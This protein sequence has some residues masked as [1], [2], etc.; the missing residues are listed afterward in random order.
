MKKRWEWGWVIWGDG[1]W[2]FIYGRLAPEEFWEQSHW[3]GPDKEF[4]PPCRV[5]TLVIY[6]PCFQITCF[7]LCQP[8]EASTCTFVCGTLKFWSIFYGHCIPY[9]WVFQKDNEYICIFALHCSKKC[10]FNIGFTYIA[11]AIITSDWNERILYKLI[12]FY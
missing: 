6:T 4:R 11:I 3:R 12:H 5:S 9:Q 1:V 2:G 7:K 10:I 8:R